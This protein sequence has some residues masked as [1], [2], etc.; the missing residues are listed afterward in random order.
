MA[1][2]E[3]W[4]N[5]K[6]VYITGGI[7][8]VML[9]GLIAILWP[10]NQRQPTVATKPVTLTW[11]KPFYGQETYAEIIDDFRKIPGNQDINIEIVNKEYN[12]DY[13]RSLIADIAK[14]AGPD[15]FT[16]SSDDLPAYKEY[17][18]PIRQFSGK[19]L[20]E[21]KTNFVDLAVRQTMD[22]DKVYAV[23]SYIENLQLYYNKNILAQS[24][25]SLPPTTWSELD[26]QLPKLNKR[27]ASTLN[28]VQSAIS[29]GTGGRARDGEP[30]ISRH[31]DIM[32]MLLFQSGGQLYD[33]Q[34][35]VSIFGNQRNERSVSSGLATSRDFAIDKLEDNNPAYR[36]IRFYNDFADITS[37]RY[38][39]NTASN[40]NIDAFV[41]GKLAYILHYS[42]LQDII[43]QRNPRLPYGVADMPQL[44]L[45]V[46]KTYG[47]FFMDGINRNLERDPTKKNQ[48]EAAEK[49]L[50]YLSQREPQLKFTSKT[51]LSGARRDVINE[52]LQGDEKIRVF[53]AGSLYADNYYKPDVNACEQIWT[54]MMERVQY[55]GQPLRE[56][57]LQAIREY[58]II[59]SNEPKL[60]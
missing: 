44:D 7:T 4:E 10:R 22:R 52:Q 15:I 50:F 40:N 54:K 53:A 57:L 24:G 3:F 31:M 35:S 56:S 33:Y 28:F 49:F 55:E 2:Q 1:L 37:T 16:I 25:I 38:S 39:W 27:D 21:Y 46:K 5:K 14:N 47:Y 42:Y 34:N 58:N 32:P 43:D 30:N 18:T 19:N 9:I 26:R 41:D 23:T 60:R 48:R 6:L 13:Y 59:V 36:A 20:A 8:V 45:N 51:K 12:N 29:L 17:M 11:W